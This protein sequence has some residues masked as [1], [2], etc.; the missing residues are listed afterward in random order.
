MTTP[1]NFSAGMR[2]L[3]NRWEQ[4]QQQHE[5][6]RSLDAKLSEAMKTT[7]ANRTG[8]PQSNKDALAVMREKMAARSKPVVKT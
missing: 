3:D 5:V 8:Q 6:A 4:L 1:T 2:T 7:T